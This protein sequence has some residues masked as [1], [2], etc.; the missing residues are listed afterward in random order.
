MVGIVTGLR[1]G[2]STNHMSIPGGGK[3]F[4]LF[5]KI[6]RPALLLTQFL[7]SVHWKGGERGGGGQID[8]DVM[9]IIRL[10]LE[11]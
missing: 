7:L 8:W 4:F 5:A 11:T 2:R 1:A 10:D 6:S 3:S 9:L